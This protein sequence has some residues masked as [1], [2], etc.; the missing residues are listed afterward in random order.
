MR[1]LK[2]GG[3]SLASVARFLEVAAIVRSQPQTE[4]VGLVLSAPHGVTNLLV[5][6]TDLAFLGT[7]YQD[8]LQSWRQR[9]GASAGVQK[10][11]I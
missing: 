8:A 7:G 2:F 1:V 3:S 11:V 4:P 9:L 10:T 6:L 5:E